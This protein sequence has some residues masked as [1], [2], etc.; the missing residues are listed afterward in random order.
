MPKKD[1]FKASREIK[2]DLNKILKTI[3]RTDSKDR[4]NDLNTKYHHLK[5][6]YENYTPLKNNNLE[7][8]EGLFNQIN[9][10]ESKLPQK[11][12]DYPGSTNINIKIIERQIERLLQDIRVLKKDIDIE[13]FNKENIESLC[14]AINNNNN[15]AVREILENANNKEGGDGNIEVFPTIFNCGI[16]PTILKLSDDQNRI[17]IFEA[18]KTKNKDI[19]QLLLKNMYNIKI[20]DNEN[21]NLFHIIT[22]KNFDDIKETVTFLLSFPELPYRAYPKFELIELSDWENN[23]EETPLSQVLNTDEDGIEKV[24]YLHTQLGKEIITT[25]NSA[26]LLYKCLATHNVTNDKTYETFKWLLEEGANYNKE[27]VYTFNGH[28]K[29]GNLFEIAISQQ[30]FDYALKIINKAHKEGDFSQI[31]KNPTQIQDLLGQIEP[32]DDNEQ[33][34]KDNSTTKINQTD[35]KIEEIKKYLKEG[36]EAKI[37][38]LILGGIEE[39]SDEFEEY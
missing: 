11:I 19:I 6:G 13:C 20:V 30:K 31:L 21:N 35:D 17:P 36:E 8:L 39:D 15:K 2:F 33:P 12:N 4:T 38:S 3:D 10:L 26:N 23:A 32:K 1:F 16:M 25:P 28:E 24:K 7:S 22:N 27:F 18:V 29:I 37:Y 34:E 5:E 14:S 9:E